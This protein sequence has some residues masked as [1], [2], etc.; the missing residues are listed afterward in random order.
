MTYVF[1]QLISEPAQDTETGFGKQGRTLN[2]SQMA[3]EVASDP[4][5]R[6]FQ[7]V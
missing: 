5:R 6:S 2:N 7:L 1:A 4:R 3:S